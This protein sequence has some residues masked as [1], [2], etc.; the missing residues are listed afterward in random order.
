MVPALAKDQRRWVR[1]EALN[2][3]PEWHTLQLPLPTNSCRP[4]CAACE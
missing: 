2:V 1:P 4:R 3:A